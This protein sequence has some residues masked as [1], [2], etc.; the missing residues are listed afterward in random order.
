MFILRDIACQA[1]G[2][3]MLEKPLRS[4]RVNAHNV[5]LALSVIR[6]VVDLSKDFESQ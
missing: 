2:A 6:A 4:R 1:V 3:Q 5:T